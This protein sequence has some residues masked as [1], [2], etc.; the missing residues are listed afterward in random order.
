MCMLPNQNRKLSPEL[1]VEIQFKNLTFAKVSE[2]M[3]STLK[4]PNLYQ[5]GRQQL[6]MLINR[7]MGHIALGG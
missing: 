6:K 4:Q 1:I 7:D 5:Q 2:C 3:Q